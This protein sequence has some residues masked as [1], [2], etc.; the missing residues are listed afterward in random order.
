MSVRVSE[1]EDYIKSHF[2]ESDVG[3]TKICQKFGITPSYFSRIFKKHSGMNLPEYLHQLRIEKAKQ[4]L[5]DTDST[6]QDIAGNTG[7]YNSRTLSRVF[8]NA[9]GVTPGQYRKMHKNVE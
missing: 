3:V 1:I 7:F 4:L 2:Y 9:E 8:K 6:V 5:V